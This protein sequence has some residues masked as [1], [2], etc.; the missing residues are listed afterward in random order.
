VTFPP[1][2]SF[3]KSRAWAAISPSLAARLASVKAV[4]PVSWLTLTRSKSA[5]GPRRRQRVG[6]PQAVSQAQSSFLGRRTNSRPRGRSCLRGRLHRRVERE[7]TRRRP[8]EAEIC[9][10]RTKSSSRELEQ[11]PTLLAALRSG[12]DRGESVHP[13][14]ARQASQRPT[15]PPDDRTPERRVFPG[16]TRQVLGIAL[17]RGCESAGLALYSPHD[18][19]H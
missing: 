15:C 18:L 19:R 13:D 8:K 2:R 11:Q 3:A 5:M 14:L 9:P 6:L 1:S 12:G 4:G 16:A 17:R 10:G 7:R